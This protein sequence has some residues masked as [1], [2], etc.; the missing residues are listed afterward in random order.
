M[1]PRPEGA[2][3]FPENRVSSDWKLIADFLLKEDNEVFR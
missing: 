3:T 1:P 2:T